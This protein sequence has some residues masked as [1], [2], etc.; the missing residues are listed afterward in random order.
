[1]KTK[2]YGYIFIP[3]LLLTLFSI[4]IYSQVPN[5]RSLRS[6]FLIVQGNYY[7]NTAKVIPP[8]VTGS[9]YQ[10][11]I[12]VSIGQDRPGFITS[13]G[14]NLVRNTDSTYFKWQSGLPNTTSYDAIK[15]APT[16][17]IFTDN[18]IIRLT[19]GSLLAMKAGAT[20]RDIP[21][22]PAWWDFPGVK[23]I[24]PNGAFG[25]RGCPNFF[26][27][28]NNGVSWNK[29]GD[30]D[31]ATVFNGDFGWPRRYENYYIGGDFDRFEIYQCP[32]TNR[33]YITLWGASGL[34]NYDSLSAELQKKARK[35]IAITLVAYSDDMCKTWKTA[36]QFN[37]NPV[38]LYMTSTP[39]GRFYALFSWGNSVQIIFNSLKYPSKF[40]D[41]IEITN[42]SKEKLG[43]DTL[44]H[45][46]DK[47]WIPQISISRAS[48]NN[49]ESKLRV[50]Y[51]VLNEYGRQY[52]SIKNI[53]M[54]DDV[55]WLDNNNYSSE[56]VMQLTGSNKIESSDKKNKSIMDGAFIDPDYID[57]KDNN[58]TSVF[59][60]IESSADDLGYA[61]QSWG[62]NSDTIKVINE[63]KIRK[64]NPNRIFSAKYCI[65]Y[66][67]NKITNPDFL[68]KN[69][70]KPR[71]WGGGYSQGDYFSGGFFWGKHL[72]P[73]SGGAFSYSKDTLNYLCQWVEPDGIH[74]NIVTVP[75]KKLVADRNQNINQKQFYLETFGG[76][77]TQNQEFT[78]ST[79]RYTTKATPYGSSTF[80]LNI[81]YRISDWVG[82]ETG[83]QKL[84]SGQ[85]MEVS[86]ASTIFTNNKVNPMDIVSI[87]LR[88]APRF[89][90]GNKINIYPSIGIKLLF[91][92]A[93]KNTN[94][95][96]PSNNQSGS[97]NL[98]VTN[99]IGSTPMISFELGLSA[100]V[101]L[102]KQLSILLKGNFN[103]LLGENVKSAF[104]DNNNL[105]L[106]SL[107]N[108]LEGLNGLLGLRFYIPK[109]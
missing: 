7:E 26:R 100:E 93:D 105:S 91:N 108:K 38:P 33:I 1:M 72:V 83:F 48:L 27:S 95:E 82:F 43:A 70:G 14:F 35:P 11:E 24:D 6:D 57:L 22:K 78:S 10:G 31:A 99:T 15:E 44:M 79:D 76:V 92:S 16:D 8:S 37:G 34:S 94:A 18:Q 40:Y 19:D 73:K 74:G 17:Q 96:L 55:Q 21:N 77:F 59:Y 109:F 61:T 62:N 89:N 104:S 13:R 23:W 36:K 87:P 5:L 97:L 98:N 50:T 85:D 69:G 106:G 46:M 4:E 29:I 30:L 64:I 51:P 67:D 58:N 39:D 102:F 47:W 71:T 63:K 45:M 68:S 20:Y 41:P 81:G 75:P 12:V 103:S 32:F 52:Y 90:I 86:Q 88:Y 101:T 66:G 80:G 53:T 49:N 107:V 3:L 54:S 2:F 65:F 56:P 42:S 9:L 84:T 60:F 25:Q 28:T